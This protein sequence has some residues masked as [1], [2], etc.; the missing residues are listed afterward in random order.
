MKSGLYPVG[1]RGRRDLAWLRILIAAVG[2]AAVAFGFWAAATATHE[3]IQRKNASA[4][5]LAVADIA[6]KARLNPLGVREDIMAELFRKLE[7]TITITPLNTVADDA[8][9]PGFMLNA[10]GERLDFNLTAVSTGNPLQPN[11]LLLE[12]IS[13]MPALACRDVLGDVPVGVNYTD[14]AIKIALW[15]VEIS[16]SQGRSARQLYNNS[17]TMRSRLSPD[18]IRAACGVAAMVKVRII[19]KLFS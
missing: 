16:D 15:Q 4:Q 6:A 19:F 17:Q 3:E 1:G 5:L 18:A 7:T 10:W 11:G 8:N 2:L 13:N 12:L 14:T 9:P